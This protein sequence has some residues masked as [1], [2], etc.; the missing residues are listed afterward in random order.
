MGITSPEMSRG[1][2]LEHTPLLEIH[3]NALHGYVDYKVD[4]DRYLS[5]SVSVGVVLLQYF[6]MAGTYSISNLPLS[7]IFTSC[8]CSKLFFY[9][10][11]KLVHPLSS[12]M[13]PIL[14]GT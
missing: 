5:C 3:N 9:I 10:N 6:F 7:G 14:K 8:S 13:I 12:T 11:G 4:G 1:K 2:I